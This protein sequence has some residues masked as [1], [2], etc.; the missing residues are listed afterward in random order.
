VSWAGGD[1][2]ELPDEY[3]D[4]VLCGMWHCRPS[5][6]DDERLRDIKLHLLFRKTESRVQRFANK[7]RGK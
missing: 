2:G 5:E 7:T 4:Y 3:T 6:L 1:S